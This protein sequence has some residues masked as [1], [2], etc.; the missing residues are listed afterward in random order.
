MCFKL[1]VVCIKS[2]NSVFLGNGRGKNI[3]CTIMMPAL[4]GSTAVFCSA[5]RLLSVCL[6]IYQF[7]SNEL[8]LSKCIIWS[9]I[10]RAT[11]LMFRSG[12]EAHG[13]NQQQQTRPFCVWLSV[14]QAK[15]EC[16][17]TLIIHC[18]DSQMVIRLCLFLGLNFKKV[19]RPF[20]GVS[21][22][23]SVGDLKRKCKPALQ[24]R[25]T[26]SLRPFLILV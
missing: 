20:L 2:I 12:H 10:T 21:C 25:S 4:L 5:G 13:A 3:W 15:V 1:H 8:A 17:W 22:R 18:N 9:L 6:M 16:C 26:I 19:I 24:V 11:V 14:R 23:I 7:Y